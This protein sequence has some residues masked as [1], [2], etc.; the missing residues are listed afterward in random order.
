M[1]FTNSCSAFEFYF[2]KIF[3]NQSVY[4]CV[5][6]EG[7]DFFM[8]QSSTSHAVALVCLPTLEGMSLLL[9][10]PLFEIQG[11]ESFDLKAFLETNFNG[12]KRELAK[13][14]RRSTTKSPALPSCQCT[15]MSITA[16]LPEGG[17]SGNH[18]MQQST[19]L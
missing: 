3:E 2:I 18:T 4:V 7:S 19:T 8:Q 12:T 11:S 5:S 9:K 1:S 17:S 10:T 15:A 6:G 16:R 14:Q 13:V